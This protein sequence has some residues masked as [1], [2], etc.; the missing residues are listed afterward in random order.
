VVNL[1]DI[2]RL[3]TLA[4]FLFFV[5][6]GFLAIRVYDL[7][8]PS[9]RRDFGQSVIDVVTYSLLNLAVLRLYPLVLWN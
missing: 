5:V 1:A 2:L 4:L 3:E 9:E 8:V 7:I 6:P